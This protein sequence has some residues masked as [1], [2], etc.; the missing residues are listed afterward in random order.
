MDMQIPVDIERIK[1]GDERVFASFFTFFYPKL[2]ALACRFVDEYVAED[3]VQEVFAAYWER[4]KTIEADRLES[5]LYKWL[6][7]RCLDYLK[8]RT[9]VNDYE[10]QIRLAR[11]RIAFLSES[12]DS[13]DV[14][15]EV[16]SRDLRSLLEEAIGKL[17]P[18]CAE[19]FRLCYFHEL[20]HKEIADAMCIS[21]RT[22]EGHIRQGL[23]HLR[24]YLR[25]RMIGIL[26]VLFS[27]F[28]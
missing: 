18:K 9:V 15:K 8:H 2:M 7:N 22:V 27:I 23:N 13:N 14:L 10:A 19:A 17:P 11:M 12:A 24:V 28:S 26:Y 20:S 1:E 4:K 6:Q 3:L 25:N 5:F 21:V 16:V